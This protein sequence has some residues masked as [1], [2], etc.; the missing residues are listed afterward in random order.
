MSAESDVQP[1]P[2]AGLNGR[3]YPAHRRQYDGFGV[4]V[5]TRRSLIRWPRRLEPART[6]ERTPASETS[7]HPSSTR[8]ARTAPAASSDAL[9][10]E[11]PGPRTMRPDRY[12]SDL[13]LPSTT[14]A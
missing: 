5:H 3:Q 12:T 6:R 4:A 1:P 13:I 14:T 11:A 9:P 7:P 8:A 2:G 10:A